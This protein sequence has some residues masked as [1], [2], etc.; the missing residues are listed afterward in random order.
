MLKVNPKINMLQSNYMLRRRLMWLIWKIV[1]LGLILKM[2]VKTVTIQIQIIMIQQ[3]VN[4]SKDN[5]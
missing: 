1:H 5:L 3:L 2:I 4:A